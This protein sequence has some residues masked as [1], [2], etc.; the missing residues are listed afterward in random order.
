MCCTHAARPD[1]EHDKVSVTAAGILLITGHLL[2][3]RTSMVLR[4]LPLLSTIASTIAV[5]PRGT[6]RMYSV[7]M[8]TDTPALLYTVAS[9]AE[10]M[11]STRVAA[12]KQGS[13]QR[14]L[15]AVHNAQCRVF[16]TDLRQHWGCSD[17]PLKCSRQTMWLQCSARRGHVRL[18]PV[19]PPCSVPPE[20]TLRCRTG[21]SQA[22]C[23]GRSLRMFTMPCSAV[24][25]KSSLPSL[26]RAAAE[27][28]YCKKR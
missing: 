5:S 24:K 8:C 12:H 23:P 27:V 3:L 18:A 1:L 9:A 4:R 2:S 13:G 14:P 22:Q 20:L 15:E 26:L 6:P 25:S 16:N 10:P 21:K 7:P 17:E 11:V 19:Q 28:K